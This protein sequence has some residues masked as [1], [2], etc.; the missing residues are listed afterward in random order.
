MDYV[1]ATTKAVGTVVVACAVGACT[2]HLIPNQRSTTRD[3]SLLVTS[4]CV[5]ALLFSHMAE[6]FTADMLSVQSATLL[7]LAAVAAGVG[8]LVGWLVGRIAL[9]NPELAF[10]TLI[11]CA[12]QN[13]V[14]LP[15]SVVTNLDVPWLKGDLLDKCVAYVFVYSVMVSILMWTIGQEMIRVAA[16]KSRGDVAAPLDP[17]TSC[18]HRVRRVAN[19]LVRPLWSGPFIATV[20]G[21]AC[22]LAG[23]FRMGGPMQYPLRAFFSAA[24]VVGSACI[25]CSLILLGVN[26]R[27]SAAAEVAKA[28]AATAAVPADRAQDGEVTARE[29]HTLTL[30]MAVTRLVLVPAAIIALFHF[31]CRPV[32]PQLGTDPALIVALFVEACAPTAIGISMLFTINNFRPGEFAKA[33]FFQYIACVG[34]ASAWITFTLW[35]VEQTTDVTAATSP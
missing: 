32:F 1:A 35:Y 22:G 5:P 26:L 10:L 9:R 4:I 15:M 16:A 8:G 7:V 23:V 6:A 21:V 12:F 14:I 17:N 13:T 11:G 25:P 30:S 27:I 2:A 19:S 24:S 18:I 3:F 20:L 34:S 33:V 31:V 28:T 29:M